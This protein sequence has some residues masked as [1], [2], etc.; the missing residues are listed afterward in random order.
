MRATSADAPRL[1]DTPAEEPD[2]LAPV[3]RTPQAFGV[4]LRWT[5]TTAAIAGDLASDLASGF[6]TASAAAVTLTHRGQTVHRD[7]LTSLEASI[8]SFKSGE[9]VSSDLDTLRKISTLSGIPLRRLC[10]GEAGG[11]E[12]PAP[13][14]VHRDPQLVARLQKLR[15]QLD[16][17]D[18]AQMVGKGIRK[19][20]GDLAGTSAPIQGPSDTTNILDISEIRT[21]SRQITA[22]INMMFSVLGVGGAVFAA[23]KYASGDMAIR[24]L[25][26]ILSAIVT[27]VAEA[28]FILRY[29]NILDMSDGTTTASSKPAPGRRIA[30]S[31]SRSHTKPKDQ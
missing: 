23:S 27:A 7:W 22:I 31:A 19:R 16:A 11:L 18:Y 26:S 12:W 30:S 25:L 8:S 20:T 14:R 4:S 13:V 15:D 2:F 9:S 5:P 24:V 21:Q 29:T 6:E 3:Y 10:A 28:W 17:T 1:A